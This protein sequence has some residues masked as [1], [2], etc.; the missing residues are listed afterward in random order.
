MALDPR[1]FL[2]CFVAFAPRNDVCC[3]GTFL[4][5]F[6][7]LGAEPLGKGV[8]KDYRLCRGGGIPHLGH[9]ILN[10]RPSRFFLICF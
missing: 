1:N 8:G 4:F 7:V 2:D 9:Y 10:P 5:A 3:V 6:G